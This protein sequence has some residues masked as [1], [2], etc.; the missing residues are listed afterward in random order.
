MWIGNRGRGVG[1]PFC[2]YNGVKVGVGGSSMRGSAGIDV[3]VGPGRV[4]CRL[5]RLFDPRVGVNVDVRLGVGV[6][7]PACPPPG[8]QEANS[9]VNSARQMYFMAVL[10]P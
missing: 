10:Y 1:N 2:L 5:P 7:V 8:R 4:G 3:F 9:K 6:V